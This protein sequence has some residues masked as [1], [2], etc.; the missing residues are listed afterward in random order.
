MI[1]RRGG[2]PYDDQKRLVTRS[3]ARA[4]QVAFMFPGQGTQYVGMGR[5]LY[6]TDSYFQ[7]QIENCLETLESVSDIDLRRF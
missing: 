2:R 7:E 6:S 5:H 1:A 4:T 3:T